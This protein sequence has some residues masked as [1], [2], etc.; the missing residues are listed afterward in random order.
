MAQ[1]IRKWVMSCEQFNRELRINPRVTRPPLENPNEYITAPEAAMQIDLVTG[2]PLSHDFENIVRARDVFSRSLFS[3]PTAIKDGK[4]IAKVINNI[5]TKH[6]YIPTTLISD[7]GTAFMSHVIKEVAGVPDITLKHATTKQAQTT[8]LRERSDASIKQTLKIETVERRSLWHKYVSNAVL[9]Y[10]TSYQANIG[11]EP[12]RVFHD[13]IPYI[14]LDLKMVICPQKI[15]PSDSQIAQ[16]VID[17]TE[18]IFQDIRRNAMQA[19]MKYKAYYDKKPNASKFKRTDH[20]YI[21]HTKADYQG[22]K[23]PFTDFR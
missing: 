8:G 19:Y 17:Q 11:C 6:A 10:N 13:C 12:N 16:D 7:K 14:I 9:N 15:L 18:M 21:S 22:S 4:T 23:I 3:Y 20:V 2:L 5:K 1:L